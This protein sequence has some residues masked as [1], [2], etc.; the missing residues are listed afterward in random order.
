MEIYNLG[1]ASRILG[2][3]F[4]TLQYLERA[5]RIPKA[6]RSSSGHRCY[7]RE[8]LEKLKEILDQRGIRKASTD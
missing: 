4:Y 5:G 6:R 2:I 8:D 7:T 1:E 3:P